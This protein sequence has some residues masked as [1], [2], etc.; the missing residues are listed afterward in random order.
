MPRRSENL[1]DSEG[2]AYFIEESAFEIRI[3]IAM[4]CLRHSVLAD[5]TIEDWRD[6]FSAL[7]L[8]ASH[9]GYFRKVVNHNQNILVSPLD[10]WQRTHYVYA[11]SFAQK[12]RRHGFQGCDCWGLRLIVGAASDAG[13]AEVYCGCG[14]KGLS[15]SLAKGLLYS[16][17]L[18]GSIARTTL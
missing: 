5:S 8:H 11:H 15:V 10:Q 12:L 14:E 1:C 7:R 9:F 6:R 3:L 17:R 4:D 13:S 2:F 18:H 16:S